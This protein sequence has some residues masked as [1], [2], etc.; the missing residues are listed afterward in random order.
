MA[1]FA[2]DEPIN[3]IADRDPRASMSISCLFH[4]V[5]LATEGDFESAANACQVPLDQLRRSI[6]E[7]EN[8]L[9][10]PVVE[11]EGGPVH[12]TCHGQTA[13]LWAQKILGAYAAMRRD[14][15]LAP[16]PGR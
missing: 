3:A 16:L 14:L 12:L 4:F 15:H 10:A 6:A 11:R 13:L 7:L 2:S 5:A 8:Y 1:S 9:D